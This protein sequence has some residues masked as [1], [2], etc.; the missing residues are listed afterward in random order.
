[1]RKDAF[2]SVGRYRNVV[3]AEDYDTVVTNRG[4][5]RTR[6]SAGGTAQVQ[7]SF[8]PGIRAY[9]STAG[10]WR[11]CRPGFAS[12]RRNGRP[13]PLS[14]MTAIT[15]ASLTEIGV[16]VAARKGS[17]RGAIYR[18]SVTCVTPAKKPL[19]S[20]WLTCWEHLTR[21]MSKGGYALTCAFGRQ[22]AYWRRRR[23]VRSVIS[24]AGALL[25]RPV[26]IGRPF[27]RRSRAGHI[28]CSRVERVLEKVAGVKNGGAAVR[29]E[30]GGR[31][32]SDSS[33]MSHLI[34]AHVEERAASTLL[35]GVRNRYV[36]RLANILGAVALRFRPPLAAVPPSPQGRGPAWNRGPASGRRPRNASPP[37]TSLCRFFAPTF[38]APTFSPP[39]IYAPQLI[40]G[41][42]P[43]VNWVTIPP[44]PGPEAIQPYSASSGISEENGYTN[45]VYSLQRVRSGSQLLRVDRSQLL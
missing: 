11:D 35:G 33:R 6:E 19:P 16:T 13:V 34:D 18:V 29:V 8:R 12:A 40:P 22:R 26:L 31:R 43:I 45:P 32:S 10:P 38:C 17:W 27:L 36:A 7:D 1:M 3:H 44:A 39:A 5:L 30:Y 23:V 24:T 21:A 28:G 2:V 37:T 25:T 14:S 4:A 20:S 41:Q 9:V 15:P 42:R